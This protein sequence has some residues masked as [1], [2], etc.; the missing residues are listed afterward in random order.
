M[1]S[2]HGKR[3]MLTAGARAKPQ[4]PTSSSRRTKPMAELGIDTDLDQLRRSA[5]AGRTAEVQQLLDRHVSVDAAD[6]KGETALMKHTGGSACDGRSADP[7]WR[8]S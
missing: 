2:T 3:S 5:A 4:S 8:E 1:C 6:S 7:Q